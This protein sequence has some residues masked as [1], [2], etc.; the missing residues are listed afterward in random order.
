M[1]LEAYRDPSEDQPD[2]EPC[3]GSRPRRV[4]RIEEYEIDGEIVLYDPQRN[5]T[6]V[7]NATSAVVWRLCDG[8]RDFDQLVDDMSILF[9]MDSAVIARDLSRVLEDFGRAHLLRHV[10]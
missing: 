8:T 3:R 4:R 10:N 6:H 9:D 5:R 2:R 7:L 1:Q